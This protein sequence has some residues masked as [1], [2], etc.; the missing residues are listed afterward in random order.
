MQNCGLHTSTATHM[1]MAV[2]V[3]LTSILDRASK[4]IFLVTHNFIVARL[5]VLPAFV[6]RSVFAVVS[7]IQTVLQ[8]FPEETTACD[9]QSVT[10]N[11][12]YHDPLSQSDELQADWFCSNALSTGH[13]LSYRGKPL[14]GLEVGKYEVTDN[15]T[16][17]LL[18]IHNVGLND[19]GEYTCRLVTVPGLYATG[20]VV[21]GKRKCFLSKQHVNRGVVVNFDFGER[22]PRPRSQQLGSLRPRA[23]RVAV[24]RMGAGGGHPLR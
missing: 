24:L 17:T 22:F 21:V 10:F 5:I 9:G 13:V 14:N 16:W 2:L 15:G 23:R 6:C 1:N 3:G 8:V 20:R 12:L 7:S 19:T 4:A 11:C 18:R